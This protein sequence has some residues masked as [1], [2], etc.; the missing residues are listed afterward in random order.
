MDEPHVTP[1]TGETKRCPFCAEEIRAEATKCKHCGS[2]LSRDGGS[3]NSAEPWYRSRTDKS[4]AGVCMGIAKRFNISITIVRVAFV[5]AACT[6]GWGILLYIALW[7]IMPLEPLELRD[8]NP[9]DTT[10]SA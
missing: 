7:F 6:G 5:L 4:I 10:K 9:L 2:F 1:K 8:G 3:F